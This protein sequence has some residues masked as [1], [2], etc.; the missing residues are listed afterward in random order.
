[1][2]QYSKSMRNR[3]LTAGILICL[4]MHP[5]S[6][7]VQSPVLSPV[8]VQTQQTPSMPVN[9]FSLQEDR[10][11]GEEAI[12]VGDKELPLVRSR[13]VNTFVKTI[14]ARLALL[15]PQQSFPYRIQVVN[16]KTVRSLTYPGGTIYVDRGLLELASNEHE[17]AAI[18]A[19]EIAHAAA[20]HGTQQL[21]RQWF[22]QSPASILGGLPG[23]AGW[24]DQLQSLGISLSPHPSFLRYNSNQEIEANRIA[25]QILFKSTY[26]PYALPA[27]FEKIN[28]LATAESRV[29]PAYVYD[30]PQ[31]TEAAQQLNLEIE[32][33]N[34]VSRILKPSVEFLQ[35]HSTLMGWA[36]PP[37]EPVPP[38][39][40][41]LVSIPYRH[42]EAYYKL[43]YPE[44][45]QATPYGSNG[46]IIAPV[47]SG[48]RRFGN[49]IQV[50]VMFDLFDISDRPMTLEQATD[51]LLVKLLQRNP[52]LQVISGAQ[53][54]M[55]MGGDP[56]LRTVLIGQSES[57]N[58][59][60][61]SWVV[62]RVYYQTLFYIVCVAPQK[63]FEKRQP[64][65]EQILKSI[66]LK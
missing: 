52:T 13:V 42:P 60:E 36:L 25:V 58:S 50:G 10:E 65:F 12:K 43:L 19:H 61:I 22:V 27:I 41:T 47:A 15:S 34:A 17:V 28:G 56:A 11:I 8:P 40:D 37:E 16:S 59:P 35:F 39:P 63:D 31:G 33:L 49:D 14:A 5:L 54:L 38:A 29:L 66:E 6:G 1:M 7:M 21:S 53:P 23:N 20:R 3:F 55:L 26:S 57:S 45:W 51:R 4:L 62:T 44:G 2:N 48:T 24:K 46:A 32:K 18:I 30:H 64:T 9:F